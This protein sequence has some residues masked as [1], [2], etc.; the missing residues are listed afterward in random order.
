MDRAEGVLAHV[1]E[2]TDDP[3]NKVSEE[4]QIMF[5]LRYAELLAIV[6]NTEQR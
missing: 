4:A 2:F 5:L 1:S 3:R 6:G